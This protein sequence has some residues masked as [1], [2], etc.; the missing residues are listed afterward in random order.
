MQGAKL[1]S[2]AVGVMADNTPQGDVKYSWFRTTFEVS[3]DW[4]GDDIIINFGAVDYEATVF[5]NVTA[6]PSSYS[7]ADGSSFALFYR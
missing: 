4:Q 1:I 6:N 7:L 3:S 5:V 2:F